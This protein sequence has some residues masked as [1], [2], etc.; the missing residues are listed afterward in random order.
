M[1][2]TLTIEDRIAQELRER[3]RRTGKPFKQ[4][5]NEALRTGLTRLEQPESE[6]YRLE[7]ASLGSPRSGIDL[8]KTLA[9]SEGL[10]DEAL[11]SK[12]EQR[13]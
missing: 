7:P 8:D 10:E 5:V 2:T 4:V 11:V 3:A 6:P 13:K 12:M 1:R 9:L